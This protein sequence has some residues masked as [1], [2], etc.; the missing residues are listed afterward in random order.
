MLLASGCGDDG[1]DEGG[2][3]GSG[4]TTTST[5]ASGFEGDLTGVFEIAPGDLTGE[6]ATGSWF[7]MIQAGGTVED[8][9]FIENA[10]SLGTDKTYTLLSPGTDG[11]LV[12]GAHQPPVDPA[13]DDQG[14][15]LVDA[16]ISPV[17]FFGVDFSLA[18]PETDPQSGD[19]APAPQLRAAGGDL[20]GDLSA[21][22]AYYGGQTFNQGSPKPGGE[23]P[24]LTSG[25]TGTIDPDTGA[26]TVEWTSQIEGGAFDGFTGIWHLEGT[27]TAT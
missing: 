10:D 13:F 8:G 27:F 9:P 16:I 20:T 5:A 21:L 6:G 15:A 1:D 11:G 14:N 17:T 12:S 25:P 26:F 7:R 2:E 23:T 24:G 19:P 4:A 3:S 18:S 22:T